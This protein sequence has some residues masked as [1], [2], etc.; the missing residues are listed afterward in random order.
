MELQRGCN[1]DAD[2]H[3][4][5]L[6]FSSQ[7]VQGPFYTVRLLWLLFFA[8]QNYLCSAGQSCSK[9][10]ISVAISWAWKEGKKFLFPQRCCYGSRLWYAYIPVFKSAQREGGGEH[11]LTDPS[12]S[13]AAIASQDQVGKRCT[14]TGRL[15]GLTGTCCL[16]KPYTQKRQ[17]ALK[18]LFPALLKPLILKEQLDRL[19]MVLSANAT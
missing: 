1:G 7:S 5:F 4:F 12:Q 10:W 8:L 19:I 2:I 18:V 11:S 16:L 17:S 6:K 14:N 3:L 9:T 15:Q 13:L